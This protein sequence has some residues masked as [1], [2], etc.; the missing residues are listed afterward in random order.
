[1]K[2]IFTII[3]LALTL[4]ACTRQSFAPVHQGYY[5]SFEDNSTAK[6]YVLSQTTQTALTTY[7]RH[8]NLQYSVWVEAGQNN[9]GYVNM[10]L[11]LDSSDMHKIYLNNYHNILYQTPSFFQTISDSTIGCLSFTISTPDGTDSSVNEVRTTTYYNQITSITYIGNEYDVINQIA[12]PQY[13]VS[14]T[15]TA[16]VNNSVSKQKRVLTNGQ[17]SFVIGCR[18]Q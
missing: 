14:G 17:Y 7:P 4:G 6:S 10:V 3:V 2:K 1:M 18:P 5:I 13:V 16:E 11:P 8:A 9:S 15:F 12:S